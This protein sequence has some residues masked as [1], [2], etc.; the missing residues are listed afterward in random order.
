MAGT[1]G[2]VFLL[3]AVVVLVGGIYLISMGSKSAPA[4]ES[5]ENNSMVTEFEALPEPEGT[6]AELDNEALAELDA[7]ILEIEAATVDETLTELDAL[8][9]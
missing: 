7:A 9:E 2:I 3:L 1:S 6:P 4:P 8:I 5:S